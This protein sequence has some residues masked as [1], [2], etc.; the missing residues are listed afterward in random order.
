MCEASVALSHH[1]CS[2]PRTVTQAMALRPEDD[3]G[4]V[5]HGGGLTRRSFSV[6]SEPPGNKNM[7]DE[8]G[9]SAHMCVRMCVCT[10]SVGVCEVCVVC[11]Y[12]HVC[13]VLWCVGE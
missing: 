8:V 2:L 13:A 10:C 5:K 12:V 6:N 3:K 7:S 1:E 9:G 4:F 11:M